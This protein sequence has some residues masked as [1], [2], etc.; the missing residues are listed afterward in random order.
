[1]VRFCS[2]VV[3]ILLVI[4]ICLK[5]KK[6]KNYYF[7][8]TLKWRFRFRFITVVSFILLRCLYL[9]ML[10]DF[11][12]SIFS[13]RIGTLKLISLLHTRT[14][15]ENRGHRGKIVRK[16]KFVYQ[17][18]F[19]LKSKINKVLFY[20]FL[21]HKQW[22]QNSFGSGGPS[23]KSSCPGG[24]YPFHSSITQICSEVARHRNSS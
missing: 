13:N 4:S 21:S 5:G 18:F 15:R 16:K 7:W 17:Y 11:F 12:F 8:E 24:D 9:L 22:R 10:R 1:M 2:S 6:S 19:K 23:N 20:K 14:G 3:D